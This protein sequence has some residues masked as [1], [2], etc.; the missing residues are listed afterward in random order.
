MSGRHFLTRRGIALLEFSSASVRKTSPVPFKTFTANV[1]G[2]TIS[3]DYSSTSTV[4]VELTSIR[5]KNHVQRGNFS[6]LQPDDVSFFREKLGQH[7][8]VTEQSDL[9]GYNVDWLRIVRGSGTVVLKPKT[10][11]EISIIL[12]YCNERNL[13]V[14]PQ[15]GNTSL[16]GG[17]VPVFDEVILSTS[18]MDSVL[19]FDEWSGVLVCEPG[20]ILEK[21][22]DYLLERD[23]IMPLDLGA[24]GSCQIGGNV[25]TNAGGLRLL[26]YGSLHSTVLG[27]EAVLADGTVLDLMSTMKKDNTG[28]DLKHLFIGAEGTLGIITKLAMQCPSK[29]NAIN[30]AFIGLNSFDKVLTTFK[31]AK[32]DLGEILSSCEYIDA[33]SMECVTGNLSLKLP[34]AQSPFYMVIETSGS[35]GEH[36]EEKLNNF[37]EE[38][39]TEN[40]VSD[41]TIASGSTQVKDL[42][43]LRERM[44]EAL[45]KDGYCYKYDLSIPLTVF[46][47][48]VQDMRTQLGEGAKRVCGYGHL[49]DSNI[50]LNITSETFDKSLHNKIEPFVYEWVAKHNGSISAEHGVG[51][52]KRD[53]LH[54]SKPNEAIGIMREIKNLLDPK[55]ILNPYKVLPDTSSS[56][57]L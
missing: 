43:A 5:Y 38:I 15:A 10:T 50:H 12:K 8:V 52:K 27:C 22:N 4:D 24:K 21:L 57:K 51:F 19:S 17:S 54:Y 2:L 33:A 36:D 48:L 23:F 56:L 55:G 42:W 46:D 7:R 35:F 14:C 25:S 26:R 18:L 44:A 28:Y 30:L 40:I 6:T 32:S 53:Y 13:A 11:E 41:G 34:I 1:R 9:A 37:L 29:P 45:L 49:G 16:V 20:C 47:E 3:R 31:R 39:M